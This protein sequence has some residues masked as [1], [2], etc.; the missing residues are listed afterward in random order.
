MGSMDILRGIEIL[1]DKV[2][3][4]SRSRYVRKGQARSVSVSFVKD[5]IENSIL[6]ISQFPES[7]QYWTSVLVSVHEI[8]SPHVSLEELS[9]AVL[10]FLKGISISAA[11]PSEEMAKIKEYVDQSI[12]EVKE[13]VEETRIASASTSARTSPASRPVVP[14]Q[15]WCACAEPQECLM[16]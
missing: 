8:D 6:T 16:Q 7:H 4:E 13:M 10:A 14:R 1:R 2:V 9:E 12:R 11:P 15:T 5:V 3:F